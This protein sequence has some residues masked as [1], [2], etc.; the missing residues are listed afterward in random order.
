M[1]KTTKNSEEE[2]SPNNYPFVKIGFIIGVTYGLIL[3]ISYAILIHILK[4]YNLK[5]IFYIAVD[6]DIIFV[7]LYA[8]YVFYVIFDMTER[9]LKKLKNEDESYMHKD[10]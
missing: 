10:N 1:D 7:L 3:L 8:I 5:P 2:I 4:M 9:A 6:I